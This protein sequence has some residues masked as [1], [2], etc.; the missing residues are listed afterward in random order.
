[1]LFSN[2]RPPAP[3]FGGSDVA[4]VNVSDVD[5]P[6][7]EDPIRTLTVDGDAA[8]SPVCSRRCRGRRATCSARSSTRSAVAFVVLVG[9][10]ALKQLVFAVGASDLRDIG[11]ERDR[12]VASAAALASGEAREL[13]HRVRE[14]ESGPGTARSRRPGR[15]HPL[16]RLPPPSPGRCRR[17][18][19]CRRVSQ[20]GG[21]DHRPHLAD[22]GLHRR[23]VRLTTEAGVDRHHQ[24]HVDEVEHV[25]DGGGRRRRVERHRGR[26][27]ERRDVA[28]ACDG[29]AV[30]ASAWTISREQPASTYSAAI[31]SG[32][33]TIRCASNGSDGVRTGRCDDGGSEREVRH[34]LAVHHVPLDAVDA[35]GLEVADRVAEPAEVDGQHARSDLDPAIGHVGRVPAATRS[36]HIVARVRAGDR[37]DGG[38][39][40]RPRPGAERPGRVRAGCDA[41]ARWSTSRSPR[42]KKD[43]ARGRLVEVVEPS[44]S[45]AVDARAALARGLRRMRLAARRPSGTAGA[46]GRDRPRGAAP[47]GSPARRPC[48]RRRPSRSARVPHLAAARGRRDGRVR[49]APGPQQ[50]RRSSSTTASSLT[51]ARIDARPRCASPARRRCRCA[52]ARN[53]RGDGVVDGR[54]RAQRE[55]LGDRVAI[56]P[57]AVL[58]RGRARR[59]AA[60]QRRVVLPVGTGGRPS[61]SSTRSA[62]SPARSSPTAST[63]VDAYG[64]VGL[65]AATAG[66]GDRCRGARRGLPIRVRRRPRQPRRP[67]RRGRRDARSR[68]G[69][70]ATPTWSSPIP[71]ATACASRRLARSIGRALGSWCSSAATRS[72]SHVTRRCCRRSAGP[73]PSPPCSTCSRTRTT[74][75]R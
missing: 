62:S 5:C 40:R 66:T 43:F 49:P 9:L 7:V 19:R 15:S 75:R 64:G 74:S 50:R 57:G 35:R 30:H 14:P 60:G 56:G 17:R 65:F 26:R 16:T 31:T 32:V 58:D 25:R 55:G 6:Q 27:A 24:H 48:R 36:L 4:G 63:I 13:V 38:R 23:D 18:P 68:S 10:V 3:L 2:V 46:Q 39:R 52:S 59:A 70:D 42:A 69:A 73:T 51:L 21:V 22:L 41:P 33:S 28:R 37:A 20:P 45:P 53:R 54:R 11:S 71:H 67:S 47:D 1:M 34:E 72:P 12:Q 61:C 8:S 29:G 44:P